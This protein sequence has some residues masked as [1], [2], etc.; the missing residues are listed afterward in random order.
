MG[1]V[2]RRVAARVVCLD[3]QQRVLLISARDPADRSK[4]AWLELPGGGLEPGELHVEAIQRELVEEAGVTD[5]TIGPCVWT[6]HAQFRFAGWDFDQ[7][8]RIHVAT[9]SGVA[10]EHTQLEAFEAAAFQG[11]RWWTLEELLSA[12]DPTVPPRLREFLPQV[13]AGDYPT[14]PIDITPIPD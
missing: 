3:P 7:H 8:E 13:I 11:Q 12:P 10:T 2:L 5:A 4:P 14:E 6:Q 9:A 1:F